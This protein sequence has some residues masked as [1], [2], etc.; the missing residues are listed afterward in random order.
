V[1]L[2]MVIQPRLTEQID[3]TTARTRFGVCSAEYHTRHPCVHDSARA[4][5]ARLQSYVE[6][7]ARQA[8]VA[9]TL[10]RFA[11]RLNL[12]MRGGI[13]SRDRMVESLPQY[14]AVHDQ[15][16][17]DWNFP[18]SRGTRCKLERK[19]HERLVGTGI[20]LDLAGR[21]QTHSHSMVA[22]GLPEMSYT[23]RLM[24]RTSLMMRLDTLDNSACGSSAQ[25]AVMKSSV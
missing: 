16:S 17:T 1:H 10:C 11:Q 24:P 4:H 18:Q 21:L 9:G 14:L 13:M 22:G 20:R 8:I 5:R 19:A 7:S 23:T 25:C 15:Y 2:R 3:D 6:C 12:G